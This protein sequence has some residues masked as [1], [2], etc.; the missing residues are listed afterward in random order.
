MTIKFNLSIYAVFIGS[1]FVMRCSSSGTQQ[2]GE[3][4]NGADALNGAQ[5]ENTSLNGNGKAPGNKNGNAA[6]GAAM[7]NANATNNFTGS[8]NQGAAPANIMTGNIGSNPD[9]NPTAVPL[10]QSVPINNGANL[11][12]QPINSAVP[13][14]VAAVPPLNSAAIPIP[15]AEGAGAPPAAPATPAPASATVNWDK[16]NASPF[17]NSQMNWPGKG[18][19]KYVTRKTTRHASPDGP[20]TGEFNVGNH[21]LVYQNGNWVEL[22]NGTYI[23]GEATSDKPV[24]YERSHGTYSH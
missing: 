12:T 5:G 22:S 13:T 4:V 8:N 3:P 1:L 15:G 7:N 17:A 20:V 14:N 21:P 11:A 10:N 9:L 16:M 18:K 24:G 19:V 23:K 2:D 6:E